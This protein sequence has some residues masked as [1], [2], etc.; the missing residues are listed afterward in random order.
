MKKILLLFLFVIPFVYSV[1]LP[2]SGE[3]S[4]E[5]ITEFAYSNCFDSSGKLLSDCSSYRD[6]LNSA[7]LSEELPDFVIL[8]F[9]NKKIVVTLEG[10]SKDYII[11]VEIKNGQIVD[12]QKGNRSDTQMFVQTDIDTVTKIVEAKDKPAVFLEALSDGKIKYQE[13]DLFGILKTIIFNLVTSL[14]NP[15]A[16]LLSVFA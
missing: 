10:D 3:T 15:I 1:E 6:G 11:F 5:A 7:L 16:G 8:L 12:I 14:I 13:N 4:I 2:D 9:D